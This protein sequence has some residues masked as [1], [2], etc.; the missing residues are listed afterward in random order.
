MLEQIPSDMSEWLTSNAL[1]ARGRLLLEE[2]PHESAVAARTALAY[3]RGS[4]N[5]EMECNALA[6][7]ALAALAVGDRSAVDTALDE[8]VEMWTLAAGNAS[9]SASLVEAGLAL[10]AHDRHQELAAAADLLRVPTPW[11]EAAHALAEHRYA[12]AAAILESIPSIP[13]RDAALRLAASG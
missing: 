9:C 10:V 11:A 2:A 3:G 4:A 7:A 5:V 12:D 8:F 13:L 1:N 6:L